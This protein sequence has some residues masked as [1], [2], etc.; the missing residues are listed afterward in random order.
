MLSSGTRKKF[1]EQEVN[2]NLNELYSWLNDKRMCLNINKT[3]DILFRPVKKRNDTNRTLKFEGSLVNGLKTKYFLV[4]G[5][6]MDCRGERIQ[7][8]YV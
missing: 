8:S 2:R 5:T 7:M 6:T 3:K 1:L 4:F